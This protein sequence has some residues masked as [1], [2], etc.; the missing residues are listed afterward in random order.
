MW[1]KKHQAVNGFSLPP[2]SPTNRDELCTQFHRI[3]HSPTA[4]TQSKWLWEVITLRW[5]SIWLWFRHVRNVLYSVSMARSRHRCPLRVAIQKVS[6]SNI[7]S[8]CSIS[9]II[10]SFLVISNSACWSGWRLPSLARIGLFADLCHW[11]A[12]YA[13]TACPFMAEPA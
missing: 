9:L 4:Y 6:Q 11:T 5:I 7:F 2:K 1:W 10:K 8:F 12:W 13:T 3:E